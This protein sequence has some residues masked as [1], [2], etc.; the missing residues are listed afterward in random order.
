MGGGASDRQLL[1][2]VR[3]CREL[4]ES[5][6]VHERSGPEEPCLHGE[7]ELGSP[8]KGNVIGGDGAQRL[9]QIVRSEKLEWR[10]TAHPSWLLSE[11]K[12]SSRTASPLVRIMEAPRV[13]TRP[14][15]S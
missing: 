6:E 5:L 10:Q 9:I 1:T 13:A 7:Q 2:S 12:K 11:V 14:V 3:D 4:R 15:T 8:G